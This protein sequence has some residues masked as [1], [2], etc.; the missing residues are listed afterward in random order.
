MD[1]VQPLKILGLFERVQEDEH[2]VHTDPDYHER[3]GDGE[4]A[5]RLVLQ[6]DSIHKRSNHPA[7][8]DSHS[9]PDSEGEGEPCQDDHHYEDDDSAGDA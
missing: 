6:D 8:N 5:E 9:S 3:R 1:C 2:V 7:H 4:Q